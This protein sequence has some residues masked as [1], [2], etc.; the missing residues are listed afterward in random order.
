MT[1]R[2]PAYNHRTGEWGEETIPL[3]E[4]VEFYQMVPTME[5]KQI[6]MGLPL[7]N[8][9]GHELLEDGTLTCPVDGECVQGKGQRYACVHGYWSGTHPD[10]ADHPA[11][12]AFHS[13]PEQQAR[14]VH[15]Q[16]EGAG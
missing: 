14:S 13:L 1:M 10:D 9:A 2:V 8:A 3:L 5:W 12:R 4:T 11:I 15:G 7:N 6:R 16:G